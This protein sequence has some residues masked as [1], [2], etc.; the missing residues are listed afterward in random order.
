MKMHA[1][2]IHGFSF[3][4]TATLLLATTTPGA[5]AQDLAV[6]GDVDGNGSVVATDALLV[7][8]TAIALPTA[9]A[10][11][12]PVDSCG[13]GVIGEGE[14][15]DQGAL[16]EATCESQGRFGEGIACGADC[17]LDISNCA[18]AR[19]VDNGD[20]TVTDNVAGLQWEQKTDDGGIHD[21]DNT[22]TWSA[23]DSAPDGQ[24]FVD[25]IGALNNC[26]EA[27]GFP[28]SELSGGFANHCDWRLP[29]VVEIQTIVDTGVANCGAGDACIDPIFGPTINYNYWT[30]T[31]FAEN[32][33]F[34]WFADFDVGQVE[35]SAK[36]AAWYVRA[37]R[38]LP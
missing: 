37:V 33:A 7:L 11:V 20:G 6:C 23:S 2:Q 28:P 32:P 4:L 35:E 10:L 22:Y 14:E 31:S 8:D 29:S 18:E 17:T 9:P 19:Y 5:F 16:G 21:K 15:C 1:A 26:V 34:A 27:G 25:F 30:A 3:C 38:S 13:D 12:C 24:A 36:S